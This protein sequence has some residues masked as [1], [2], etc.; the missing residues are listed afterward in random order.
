MSVSTSSDT[1]TITL[2]SGTSATVI[3]QHNIVVGKLQNGNFY[4][5]TYLAQVV[6]GTWAFSSTAEVG[7]FNKI[8]V[9]VLTN[10]IY[11]YE[12]SYVSVTGDFVT[13]DQ[14]NIDI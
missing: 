5:G 6:P 1:T 8:Y 11:K 4:K 10:S 12:G 9:D 13:Y 3:N 2:K 14:Y 7:N